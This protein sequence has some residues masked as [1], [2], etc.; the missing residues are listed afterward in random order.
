MVEGVATR[1]EAPR[2][3]RGAP[4]AAA[5]GGRDH[6]KEPFIDISNVQLVCPTCGSPPGSATGSRRTARRSAICRKCGDGAV[7]ATTQRTAP[8][9]KDALP[10]R[11]PARSSRSELGLAERDAGTRASRR[12]SSTWAWARPSRTPSCWTRPSRTSTIITGQKPAITKAR[13]SIAGVQAPR[14]HADRR[15]GHPAGRPDVGV[16]RP[17]AVDRRFPGSGTSVG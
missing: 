15:Q 7:M 3:G 9:L 2:A 1:D 17:A 11:A 12:S 16:P 5:P 6:H 10:R 4:A 13:K 14:G 8:R